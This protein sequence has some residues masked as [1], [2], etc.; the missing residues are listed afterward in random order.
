MKDKYSRE[1]LMR[2][3]QEYSFVAYEARLYLDTHPDS[4]SALNC[5]NKFNALQLAAAREL[6]TRYGA[7]NTNLD[8]PLPEWSWT[9]M[10][11]PWTEEEGGN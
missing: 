10:P 7:V 11:W 6:Q 1:Y 4:R 5:F 9:A 2:K 3:W 8:M